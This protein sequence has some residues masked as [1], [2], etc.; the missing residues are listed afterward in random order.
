LTLAA[1][2]FHGARPD[3]AANRSLRHVAPASRDFL[4]WRF[5]D[6]AG[7][8]SSSESRVANALTAAPSSS[9]ERALAV[10]ISASAAGI[11][12]VLAD[13]RLHKRRALA[14]RPW[15]RSAQLQNFSS[16]GNRSTAPPD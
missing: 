16:L 6:P 11:G 9:R 5:S 2:S 8:A 15:L 1:A 13:R 14:A 4:P 3:P 7:E 10:A 12:G